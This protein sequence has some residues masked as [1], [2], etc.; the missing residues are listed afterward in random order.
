MTRVNLDDIDRAIITALQSDGR[1]SYSQL[2]R[3]VGLSDAAVRQRVTRLITERIIEVVAV[4]DPAKLG[5][6]FQAMLGINVN[7]DARKVANELGSLREAVYVV[8]TAGRYDLLA[9]IVGDG[10]DIV[11]LVSEIRGLP[12]VTGVEVM[13]YLSISKETYDWGVG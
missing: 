8:L 3:L 9:E 13:P 2:G 4:T 1:T 6:G 5:L 12:G 11:R 10:D 7:D